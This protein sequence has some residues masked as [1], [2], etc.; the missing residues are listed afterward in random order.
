L[1]CCGL[2]FGLLTIYYGFV[3]RNYNPHLG[4]VLKRQRVQLSLTLY[5]LSMKSKISASHL[6]RIERGERFPSAHIL[7]RIAGPLGFE[8]KELF[9]LAGFLGQD[10]PKMA[11]DNTLNYS[12][13]IDPYVASVLAGEPAEVQRAAAAIIPICKKPRTLTH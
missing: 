6:G 13:R 8:E 9:V 1:S 2:D 3:V 5:E 4:Q 11:D 12:R 7:R 10:L